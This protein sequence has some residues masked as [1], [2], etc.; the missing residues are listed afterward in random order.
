MATKLWTLHFMRICL[1][2]L[3]LFISLYLLYPVLPVV[4]ASR[5]GVPV[6]QTGGIYILFT[7]AMFFIGPFHAY[8]VDVYKRKYICMLSF[9]IMVAAT[10]GYTL[11]QSATHLLLL[12]LVQGISFG[13]AAT[14]G[15]TLAIDVT[16]STFRSAGNVV[17]SW[18]ARLGMIIGTAL[19]V[20]LFRTHGFETLLYVSVAS[21]ALGMLF[22][23]RVYVPFRAPIGMKVCSMDRFLLP[24][25][26]IPAFNL[27]LIAFVPGLLLPVLA[28]APDF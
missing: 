4:M 22:V 8:L 11:V 5:L 24:R 21:G 15:I 26:F 16:N 2:N 28:G 27:M 25:G 6:S 9:G 18:A 3:L 10:A 7:L 17:F 1:A 13:M 20:F 23:S 12:C 19:G 14:A